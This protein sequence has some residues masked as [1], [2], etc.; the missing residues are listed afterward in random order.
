MSEGGRNAGMAAAAV[1][2]LQILALWSAVACSW[3]INETRETRK[4][5]VKFENISETETEKQTNRKLGKKRIDTQSMID[6]SLII[7]DNRLPILS[8]WRRVAL[9]KGKTEGRTTQ[10]EITVFFNCLC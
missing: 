8:K 10:R 1:Q 3:K 2:A 5:L 6:R 9:Q 4:S 7:L